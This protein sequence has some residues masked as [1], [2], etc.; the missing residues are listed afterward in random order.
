[1]LIIELKSL[2]VSVTPLIIDSFNKEDIVK[3]LKRIVE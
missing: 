2:V 1:M 3:Q